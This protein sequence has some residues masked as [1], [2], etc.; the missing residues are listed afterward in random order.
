MQAQGLGLNWRL[1]PLKPVSR[2]F[3]LSSEHAEESQQRAAALARSSHHRIGFC[4]EAVRLFGCNRCLNVCDGRKKK[5][6]HTE[7]QKITEQ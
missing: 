2:G 5:L 7:G 4:R 6:D 3:R 1:P